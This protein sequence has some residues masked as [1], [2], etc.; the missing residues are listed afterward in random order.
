[1]VQAPDGARA[2]AYGLRIDGLGTSPA[3]CLWDTGDWPVIRVVTELSDGEPPTE[4]VI[5][6]DRAT[7]L[8]AAGVLE[9]DRAAA[10]LTIRS[11]APA[12]LLDIVHPGLWPAA[13]V[14]ARWRGAETLHAGAFVPAG[15]AGAWAVMADSG[16]GKSSLLAALALMGAEV[17]VDDLLVLE[18]DGC[19]AGPRCID[20]RPDTLARLAL[21]DRRTRPVRAMG[22]ERLELPPC[23]GHRPLAGFVELGWGPQLGIERLAPSAAL[24]VLARHR[25]VIGLGA[26]LGALLEL[27]GRPL[28]RLVRPVG[29]GSA[30]AAVT[31]LL[32]A[33]AATRA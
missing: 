9:L 18:H 20:L 28:L 16:G 19:R 12:P 5:T 2:A 32:E 21:G 33:I 14:F 22:R 17:L 1:M 26:E 10:T 25:R 15:A 23:G 4:G 6:E 31:A 7:I 3:L 24:A 8:G 27:A 29:W 13:A 30:E 11:A